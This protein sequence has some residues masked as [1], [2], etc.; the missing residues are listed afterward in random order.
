M[1]K[2]L[3]IILVAVMCVSAI[4]VIMTDDDDVSATSTGT[5]RPYGDYYF[6]YST[7]S[8]EYS[9]YDWSW[10]DDRFYYYEEDPSPIVEEFINGDRDDLGDHLTLD[11]LESEQYYWAISPYSYSFRDDCPWMFEKAVIIYSDTLYFPAGDYTIKCTST[12]MKDVMSEFL[13]LGNGRSSQTFNDGKGEVTMTISGQSTV[14]LRSWVNGDFKSIEEIAKW[15]LSYSVSPSLPDDRHVDCKDDL[16]IPVYQEWVRFDTVDVMTEGEYD[17]YEMD[18][19]AFARD[20]LEEKAFLRDVVNKGSFDTEGYE[21]CK[22]TLEHDSK[23]VL[24][25]IITPGNWITENVY[26]EKEGES[27]SRSVRVTHQ[28]YGYEKYSFY[29]GQSF[30]IAADYDTSVYRWVMFKSD[31]V[32]IYMAPNTLYDI[33]SKYA[34]DYQMYLIARDP[35]SIDSSEGTIQVNMVDVPSPDGSIGVFLVVALLLAAAAFSLLVFFGRRNSWGDDAG[36][37]EE[38]NE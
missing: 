17:F 38:K 29:S 23:V 12:T 7:I 16:T 31:D 35:Y 19:I 14:Y 5:I 30:S 11:D 6:W 18:C 36:L 27:Y 28:E 13:P 3:A 37:P 4:P 9:E 15:S 26:Y 34:K 24:F 32:A 22:V 8:R 25:S 33:E 10:F 1:R 21:R 2:M 20:S